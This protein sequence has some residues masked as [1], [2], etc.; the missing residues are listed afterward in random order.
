MGVERSQTLL[1]VLEYEYVNLK[2]YVISGEPDFVGSNPRS[3]PYELCDLGQITY[4][5]L[6]SSAERR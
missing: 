5:F 1:L 4:S 3:G 6:P 2:V